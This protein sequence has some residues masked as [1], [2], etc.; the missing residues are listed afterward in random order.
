MDKHTILFVDDE[1]NILNSLSRIFRKDGYEILR[2][3]NPVQAIDILKDHRVHLI[4]SDYRMPEMDGITFLREAKRLQP[5]AIRIIL[6]G[7]AETPVIISAIND[8]GIHKFLT[9]PWEDELLR[10]EVRH[11][12]ERYELAEAN[13]KLMEDIKRRNTILKDINQLLSEKIDEVQESVIST[14]EML[15]YLSTKKD[16]RLPNNIEAASSIGGEVGKRLGLDEDGLKKLY[17]AIRLH[18]VGNIGIDSSILNKPGA[19]TPEEKR[20]VEKHPVVGEMVLSFLKGFESVAKIIRCHHEC[21]DGSGYP[22]GLKGEDIPLLSRI[23][24]I[25]DVYDS[26]TSK[27]PYRA[28]M[29]VEDIRNILI[30]WKGTKFDPVVLDTFLEVARLSL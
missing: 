17:V 29:R 16:P 18:D 1:I 2:S 27:R 11:A 24:H 12:L 10:I 19:L 28:A 21:Y 30:E 20:E 4:L 7:Y 26:L 3:D 14:I 5:D 8:G 13:L 23:V 6:S 15:S 22:D 9:K 25:V